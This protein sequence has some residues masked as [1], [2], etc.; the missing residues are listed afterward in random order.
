MSSCECEI[1]IDNK[2]ERKT[3][4]ALL[5]INAAMFVAEMVAGVIGDSTALIADSLDMFAD[6]SVYALSLYAVGKSVSLKARAAFASGVMQILLGM[7]VLF[8]VAR[9][10]V[11]GSEPV[12]AF[13]IW[14]GLAALVSN[15]ICLKLI[16][17][18]RQG[19]V[20]MRASWIFS[21]NDVIANIGVIL[22][23]IL[24]AYS[25]SHYPDLVI[26]QVVALIV[27]WGGVRII[28]EAKAEKQ[29]S[30]GEDAL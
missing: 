8:E 22:A 9:R 17:R 4:I 10:F 2:A 18:H 20:H 30:T 19:G 12:P 25:G 15:V 3:L 21:R 28:Q 26:G 23:G 24:V 29:A 16:A 14:V 27:V 5:A 7:F 6:A 1:T 11:F 13:M